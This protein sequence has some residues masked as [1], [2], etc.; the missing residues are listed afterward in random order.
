MDLLLVGEYDSGLQFICSTGPKKS[1]VSFCMFIVWALGTALWE[2]WKKKNMALCL[3]LLAFSYEEM[4]SLL[5]DKINFLSYLDFI[6]TSL[7]A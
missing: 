3:E 5:F 6:M 1:S 2:C 7:E 4:Y